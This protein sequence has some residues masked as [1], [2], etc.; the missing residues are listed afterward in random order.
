MQRLTCIAVAALH[1]ARLFT[2]LRH[3][4]LLSAIATGTGHGARFLTIPGHVAFFATV[5]AG[6]AAARSRVR[7]VL[8]HMAHLAAFATVY[9]SLTTAWLFDALCWAITKS[10]YFTTTIFANKS[11]VVHNS[12]LLIAIFGNVAKFC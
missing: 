12:G 2:I 11:S 1:Y 6:T 4:P 9:L 10:M 7:A 5:V 3:M 8:R